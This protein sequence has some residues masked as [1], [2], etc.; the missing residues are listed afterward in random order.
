MLSE[1]QIAE[2]LL[3]ARIKGY[4]EHEIA[5]G[6]GCGVGDVRRLI[7]L[8]LKDQI[9]KDKQKAL[10]N[11]AAKLNAMEAVAMRAAL[12]EEGIHDPRAIKSVLSIM[13]RR[14]RMLGYDA[15]TKTSLTDGNG[16]S[17]QNV[18]FYIPEN[19]RD[20]GGID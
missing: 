17:M 2:M 10:R 4:S 3:Q 16:N 15:P 12:N 5:L 13:A 8:A 6:Q 18:L 20:A 1:M 9:I 19:G 14:S 11:E 7:K